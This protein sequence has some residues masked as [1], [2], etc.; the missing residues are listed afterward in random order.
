MTGV[1][2]WNLRFEFSVG[3]SNTAINSTGIG[4]VNDQLSG[5]SMQHFVH[6]KILGTPLQHSPRRV[7]NWAKRARSSTDFDSKRPKDVMLVL[8]F[9]QKCDLSRIMDAVGV[10]QRLR[11]S[12]ELS[13][14][15][16]APENCGLPIAS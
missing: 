7:A 16:I 3:Y 1:A 9:S 4:A 10:G 5:S 11:K 13:L 12:G 2:L 14:T 15:T 8:N 6:E